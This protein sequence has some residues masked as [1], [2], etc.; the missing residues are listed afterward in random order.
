VAASNK[1]LPTTTSGVRPV[2]NGLSKLAT[3]NY[4]VLA[5]VLWCFLSVCAIVGGIYHCRANSY[6]YDIRCEAGLCVLSSTIA[7]VQT[8]E[9]NREDIS[10]VRMVRLNKQGEVVDTNGMRHRQ[11]SR[12]GSTVQFSFRSTDHAH[13]TTET[14]LFPPIDMGGNT[15]AAKSARRKIDDYI[16]R[17]SDKPLKI[18]NG[19]AVTVSGI[20]AILGGLFS[21]VL[22]CMIG[23]WADRKVQINSGRGAGFR[24]KRKD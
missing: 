3:V 21:S 18:S 12:L 5:T 7:G 24:G 4:Y 19:R 23:S 17:H 6:S 15:R 10:E 8:R 1:M 11:L 13:A 20:L 9:I 14:I 22:S 16:T 2:N